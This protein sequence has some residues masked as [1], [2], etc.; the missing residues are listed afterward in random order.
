MDYVTSFTDQ[1]SDFYQKCNKMSVIHTPFMS[2][3]PTNILI[4]EILMHLHFLIETFPQMDKCNL[5][6]FRKSIEILKSTKWNE[7]SEF[8]QSIIMSVLTLYSGWNNQMQ[9]STPVN[10]NMSG[11][12]KYTVIQG[13]KHSGQKSC[14]VVSED[15]NTLNMQ[16]IP[17]DKLSIIP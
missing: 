11:E 12:N 14:H 2:G 6:L 13:G 8:D 10:F 7:I 3:V 16:T 5:Q 15:D 17:T 9:E 1:K 4:Q